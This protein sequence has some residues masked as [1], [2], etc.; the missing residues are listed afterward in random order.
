MT[1]T[2]SLEISVHRKNT[3]RFIDADSTKIALI[4]RSEQYVDG[5]KKFLALPPRAVQT[6]KVIWMGD[7]GVV[8]QI[9]QTPGG[10]RRFDFVLLGEYDAIIQIGDCWYEGNQEFR[11]E[12]VYPYNDYE[13][14][15]GGVTH[16]SKPG[17]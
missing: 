16:G 7:D 5:T 1:L 6:L 4:P 11:I 2:N 14:K 8:R 15:A 10:V 17:G 12:Y 13:V 3:K 9:D